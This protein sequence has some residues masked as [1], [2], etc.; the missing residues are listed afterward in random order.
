M[1]C[2]L[3]AEQAED[4]DD[5]SDDIVLTPATKRART[6]SL[7][8]NERFDSIEVMAACPGNAFRKALVICEMM[9]WWNGMP[10]TSASQEAVLDAAWSKFH[11]DPCIITLVA[12]GIQSDHRIAKS[13]LC[14]SLKEALKLRKED[15]KRQRESMGRVIISIY[16]YTCR[17]KV[18]IYVDIN[19]NYF[20]VLCSVFV[21]RRSLSCC[22][23][24]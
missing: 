1:P 13:S 8:R 22:V 19:V 18:Y 3:A 24:R 5:S 17:C 10:Q 23:V 2:L 16:I 20:F 21:A 9:A 11:S 14:D 12:C 4:A 6:T 15:M 7:A